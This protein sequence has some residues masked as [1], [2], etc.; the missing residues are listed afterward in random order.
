MR[1]LEADLREM[2]ALRM[3]LV[4]Y[5]CEEEKSFKLDECF[6]IFSTFCDRFTKAIQVYVISWKIQNI[7]MGLKY[8]KF[9]DYFIKIFN[10]SLQ[11]QTRFQLRPQHSSNLT[12]KAFKLILHPLY[13][14]LHSG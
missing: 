8:K 3:Q 6:K 4:E 14:Y 10:Q 13:H 12:L 7:C 5:F 11:A 2:E 1:S 9:R